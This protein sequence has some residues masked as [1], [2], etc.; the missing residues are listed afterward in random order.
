MA[1]NYE[2][3]RF[4]AVETEKQNALNNVNNVYNNMVNETQGYYNDLQNAAE[5]YGRTQA[6]LQQQQSDYAI[7]TIQQNKDQLEKDYQREQRGAYQDWQKQSNRYGVEAE[8]QAAVGLNNTGYS[9]SS[10]VSMYNTYQNR[11]SQARDTYNRAVTEYDN[12]MTQARLSNNVQLA[13]IA[14]QAL[15]TKLQLGLEGF[16]YKNGLLTQQ[17]QMQQATE[18]RYYNRWQDVLNQINTENA[19]AEQQRQ[20]NIQ[21]AN[22]YSSGGGGSSGGSSSSFSD[23]SSSGKSWL[24]KAVDKVKNNINN[25]I[26]K[27]SSSNSIQVGDKSVNVTKTGTTTYEG[28]KYDVYQYNLNGT[29]HAVINIGGEWYDADHIVNWGGYVD[30]RDATRGGSSG[31]GGR[32]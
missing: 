1:V 27:G 10:Q 19:L 21:M 18:D 26:Q 16:Q 14:Y 29:A 20:F 2:D 23:N 30:E 15:Q 13:Q 5:E 28:K 8:R 3:D 11:V 32:A 12:Q 6:E 4:K 24:T 7:Q 25:A 9:E 22:R 17:L 31:G